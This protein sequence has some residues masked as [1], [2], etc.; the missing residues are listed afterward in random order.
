MKDRAR[1]GVTIRV[2]ITGASAGIGRAA[3][4]EFARLGAR[5]A[6][7]ARGA[8]GLEGARRDVEA[9]GGEALAIATD[10]AD[11]RQVEAAA[12]QVERAWG[13]IDVWVNNAMATVFSPFTDVAPEDFRRVAEVTWLGA[14]WGTRAAL[15]RMLPANRGTVVQVGSALAYRSIPLQSAYCGAKA[16]LRA[17]T[18]SVRS[19]L[20]HMRSD[21][22]ITHVVLGA[23]N[24]PQ[25]DWA[26]TTIPRKPRPVGTLYQPEVA[27]RAIVRAATR[28]RR[29]A[30]VGWA[31]VHA[32]VGTMFFPGLLDRLLARKAWKGQVGGEPVDLR[33]RP[34]NLHW[35][36]P[37]D[38]GA[39]G[40]FDAVARR[41][42]LQSRLGASPRLFAYLG[43]AALV[44]LSVGLYRR[45]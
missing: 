11:E 6:L 36:V 38:H 44:A 15:S 40:R 45:R 34:D 43:T 14:V 20:D 2:V 29:E 3:A 8:E 10:V 24:T 37:R 25:F 12:A 33:Q 22:R 5:V 9:A 35:P 26:R 27:A 42:S 18:D 19:E 4:I 31:A 1:E 23:F 13:G 39:H 32:V 7:L 21:V 16:A 17:F 30:Y 28:P 41:T